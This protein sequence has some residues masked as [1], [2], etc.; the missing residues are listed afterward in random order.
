[1]VD[2]AL[3]ADCLRIL[4]ILADSRSSLFV[5][6]IGFHGLQRLGRGTPLEAEA[7]AGR[8]QMGWQRAS[9]LSSRERDPVASAAVFTRDFLAHGEREAYLRLADRLG[10]PRQPS[11]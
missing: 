5:N 9:Q 4:R 8:L 1:M 3:R 2:P 7:T 6:I 11:P 10:M